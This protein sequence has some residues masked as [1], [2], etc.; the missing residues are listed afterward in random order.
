LELEHPQVPPDRFS[1][2]AP[3]VLAR[4]PK[5]KGI[6]TFCR[7]HFHSCHLVA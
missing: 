4:P 6:L 1:N 5:S 2:G 7:N 3:G